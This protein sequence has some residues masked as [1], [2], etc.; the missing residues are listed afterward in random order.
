M[1]CSR[2]NPWFRGR[3]FG[4]KRAQELPPGSAVKHCWFLCTGG[5]GGYQQI[6]AHEGYMLCYQAWQLPPAPSVHPLPGSGM[7]DARVHIRLC[8]NDWM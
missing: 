5:G 2:T 7:S 3:I 8:L 1:A 4:Q 6:E